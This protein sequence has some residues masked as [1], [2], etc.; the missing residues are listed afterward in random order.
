MNHQDSTR[1]NLARQADSAE[2][3]VDV[4][5]LFPGSQPHE[6]SDEGSACPAVVCRQGFGHSDSDCRIDSR[7]RVAGEA[8]LVRGT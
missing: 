3:K 6:D 2:L 8:V 7:L 4:R 5:S 1:L